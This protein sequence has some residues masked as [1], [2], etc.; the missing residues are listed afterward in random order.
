MI[1]SVISK[2]V[3][4]IRPSNP[5]PLEGEVAAGPRWRRGGR[6]GHGA[7]SR[8][9][10]ERTIDAVAESPCIFRWHARGCAPRLRLAMTPEE[11]RIL[12]AMTPA[13]KLAAAEQLYWSARALKAA[14]LRAQ[15]P[16]WSE[17]EIRR[18]VREI[19]LL[20]RS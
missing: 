4:E 8:R 17:D 18:K 14:A 12:R 9:G 6:R 13:Q 10:G 2:R 15:H 3:M 11:L 7:W 19:F 20:A 16:D 1:A 5:S